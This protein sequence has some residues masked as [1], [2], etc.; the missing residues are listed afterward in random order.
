[1][2][3]T[4]QLPLGCL[5]AA[6][7]MSGTRPALPSKRHG[8]LLMN[9]RKAARFVAVNG[10]RANL[11]RRSVDIV[12][13][14]G[15]GNDYAIEIDPSIVSALIAALIGETRGLRANLPEL[16]DLPMQELRTTQMSVSMS[17]D[18]TLA[19][20]ISLAGDIHFDLAFSPEQFRS[21]DRKMAMVRELIDR[22]VQ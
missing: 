18:G 15:D 10:S 6:H 11:E 13:A 20:R 7:A 12:L 4:G 5:D 3:L 22:S 2:V 1:M 16:S 21:L 14:G 17:P 8:E 9:V 19:W